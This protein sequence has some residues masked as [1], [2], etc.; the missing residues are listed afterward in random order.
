MA[1]RS[2]PR[3]LPLKERPQLVINATA[4]TVEGRTAYFQELYVPPNH[5]K[6]LF[7]SELKY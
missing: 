6:L 5:R 4:Y 2:A 7:D 1:N 3:N